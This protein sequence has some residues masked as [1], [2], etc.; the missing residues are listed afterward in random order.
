MDQQLKEITINGVDYIRKADVVI[1]EPPSKDGYCIVR[2]CSAGVFAGYIKVRNGKEAV[3]SN[4]RRL[5]QWH[6]AASLSQLAVD[7]TS[8]P[9]GCKFPV[10]VPE[11]ILTDVIEILP[12]TDNARI[13][14]QAVPV[15]KA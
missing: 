2:T 9:N 12:C 11:V 4:A 10:A 15:W 7:G 6:G 3:V 1:A 14:I 13:S 8:K 5:W